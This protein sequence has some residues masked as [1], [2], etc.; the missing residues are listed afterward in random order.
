MQ[1]KKSQSA[2]EFVILT[3]VVLAFFTI[4]F[5]AIQENLSDKIREKNRIEIK[6]VAL[7]IQ[8]E[9]NLAFESINGY[10]REFPIPSTLGGR[11]YDIQII[12]GLVYLKTTDEKYAIALPIQDIVGNV[13]KG[14]NT[15]EKREGKI[16]L[17]A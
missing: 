16:Y 6:N 3:G 9:I 7:T 1:N 14:D 11:E 13:T 8:D 10:K 12:E 15:I 5:I 17:N 2:F 4:F